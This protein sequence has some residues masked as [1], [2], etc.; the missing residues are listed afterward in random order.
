MIYL[1]NIIMN[2]KRKFPIQ[3]F[4]RIIKTYLDSEKI[5]IKR[6]Q[7]TVL[8]V[9]ESAQLMDFLISKMGGMAKS[10]DKQLLGQRRVKDLQLYQ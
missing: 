8:K 4:I 3:C 2:M 6:K 1:M 10:S 9:T 7:D 5:M